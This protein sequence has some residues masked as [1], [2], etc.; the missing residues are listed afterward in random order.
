M[1]KN[2]SP[3]VHKLHTPSHTTS[4]SLTHAL[5]QRHTHPLSA[6]RAHTHTHRHSYKHNLSQPHTHTHR[7][8]FTHKLSYHHTHTHTHTH[9]HLRPKCISDFSKF[10]F[11]LFFDG[12]P[13][14]T[15]EFETPCEASA[16]PQRR[17]TKT[18]LYNLCVN[19]AAVCGLR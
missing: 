2:N 17:I 19:L 3:Q 8:T 16:N 18:A 14:D 6:S 10:F 4:T 9:T 1:G 15:P 11:F 5:T 12:A 7:H 13:I